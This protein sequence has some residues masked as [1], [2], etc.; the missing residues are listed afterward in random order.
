VNLAKVR[1]KVAGSI[2]DPKLEYNVRNGRYEDL[3]EDAAQNTNNN[4][5][6]Q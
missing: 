1:N 4:A 3:P 5:N 2:G 6:K